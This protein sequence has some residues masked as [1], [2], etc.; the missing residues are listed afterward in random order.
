MT[1]ESNAV[2]AQ[3]DPS[4]ASGQSRIIRYLTLAGAFLPVVAITVAVVVFRND[5]E[6]LRT[7]R[8]PQTVRLCGDISRKRDRQRDFHPACS[9]DRDGHPRRGVLEPLA[10]RRRGSYRLDGRGDRGLPCRSG[11]IRR[12]PANRW[13]QQVVRQVVCPDQGMDRGP[14]HDHHIPSSRPHPIPSSIS[15]DSRLAR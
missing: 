11:I 14:R 8:R 9:R 3:P 2:D 5:L 6:A 1:S 7:R 12:C 15:R 10:R 13:P 4:T